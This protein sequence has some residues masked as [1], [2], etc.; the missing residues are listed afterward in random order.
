MRCG[1]RT[2]GARTCSSHETLGDVSFELY[3]A[4]M[5]HSVF[6][7]LNINRN[8]FHLFHLTV[9]V[10]VLFHMASYC[11]PFFFDKDLLFQYDIPSFFPPF[12]F[13]KFPYLSSHCLASSWISPEYSFILSSSVLPTLITMR[14]KQWS[15]SR[16]DSIMVMRM[17]VVNLPCMVSSESFPL[18]L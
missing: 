15:L 17:G 1:H 14:L 10:V 13:S 9:L 18:S 5:S 16:F 12:P 7:S 11:V 3:N 6:F 8:F 2:K 4:R